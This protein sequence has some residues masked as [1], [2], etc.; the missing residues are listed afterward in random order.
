MCSHVFCIP[1]DGV[2]VIVSGQA[3][4]NRMIFELYLAG[5]GVRKIKRYLEVCFFSI[6][7]VGFFYE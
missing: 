4:F 2:L 1:Q 3:K 6:P 7:R 5:S